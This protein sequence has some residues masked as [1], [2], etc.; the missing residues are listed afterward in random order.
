MLLA[1]F[2]RRAACSHSLD[3]V[4]LTTRVPEPVGPSPQLLTVQQ[5]QSG[6]DQADI[7]VPSGGV[8]P[9]LSGRSQRFKQATT[10]ILV[11]E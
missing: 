10:E 4:Q 7:C 1:L 9:C 6:P 8:S 2:W 3:L 11:S 5:Q